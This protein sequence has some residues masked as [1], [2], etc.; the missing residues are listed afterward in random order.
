MDHDRGFR[1][2]QAPVKSEARIYP[3]SEP[4]VSEPAPNAARVRTRY[5]AQCDSPDYFRDYYT[6]YYVRHE[7]DPTS[8]CG[9]PGCTIKSATLGIGVVVRR[10]Q[11]VFFDL[12]QE[13]RAG[14]PRKRAACV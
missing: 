11:A 7:T 14:K 8:T 5:P 10:V 13:G 1:A 3:V 6:G 12:G 9:N 2:G 4:T